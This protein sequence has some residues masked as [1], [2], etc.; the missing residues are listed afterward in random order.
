MNSSKLK[1]LLKWLHRRRDRQR[2]DEE[3]RL[4]ADREAYERG[5][6]DRSK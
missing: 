6:P 1:T 5:Y 2:A 4:A 3:A